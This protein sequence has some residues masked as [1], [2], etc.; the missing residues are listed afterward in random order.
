MF[1]VLDHAEIVY[2]G[3]LSESTRYV[4]D[5]YGQRLDEAVRCG[6][7]ILYTDMLHG[8]QHAK[9][10]ARGGANP[11]LWHPIADWRVD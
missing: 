8:L 1:H 2:S 9:E 5:R 4:I 11:E 3:D 10:V 6:V 7:R